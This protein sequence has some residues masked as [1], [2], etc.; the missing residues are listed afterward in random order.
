MVVVDA[1]PAAVWVRRFSRGWKP[2]RPN[3]RRLLSTCSRPRRPPSSSGKATSSY[4]V[5]RRP[6]PSPPPGSSAPCARPRRLSSSRS[7]VPNDPSSRLARSRPPACT[8]PGLPVQPAR[9][10]PRPERASA[11]HPAV[12]RLAE[13]SILFPSVRRGSC[14]PVALHGLRDA[15]LRSV[16]PAAD[17]S[18]RPRTTTI[19]RATS[20]K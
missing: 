9:A 20:R 16:E 15:H 19:P 4:R 8:R 1:R 10:G 11:A 17:G 5:R 14:P 18:S 13:G 2:G 3:G 12:L 7:C 6:P